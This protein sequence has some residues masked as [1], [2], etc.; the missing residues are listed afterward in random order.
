MLVVTGPNSWTYAG[1]MSSSPPL[2][3]EQIKDSLIRLRQ[4]HGLARPTAV[5]AGLSAPVRAHLVK[6][7]SVEQGSAEEVTQLVAVLRR[8]IEGLAEDERLSVE[9]D[10]NLVAEHRYRTLTERQESLARLQKCAAKTV[11]RH[12]DRALETLAYVNIQP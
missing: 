6:E 2:C 5:L 9:V 4:G 8:A 7:T 11:R 12:A 10:F 1:H 3:V